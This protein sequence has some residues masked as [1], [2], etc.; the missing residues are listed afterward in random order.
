MKFV[1]NLKTLFTTLVLLV[2]TLQIY[3]AGGGGSDSSADPLP[4]GIP[5]LVENGQYQEAII[6]LE[7]FISDEKRN[8]D[9]WNYLGYSQRKV[10]LLDESLKSYK[11]AL[12][13]DRKH[14]GANEYI[15]EL[16]LMLNDPKKAKKHLKRLSKY[17]G[18]C[19][20][21]QDLDQAIDKY[22]QGS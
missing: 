14:L 17:C 21:Y 15:G 10:G 1:V 2:F 4:D 6:A 7:D 3:A 8:A 13:L 9:A 19:E 22:E 20:Q 12:K 5:A 11:K 16:Y 18:D